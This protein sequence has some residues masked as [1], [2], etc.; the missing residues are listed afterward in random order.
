VH[1]GD[2]KFHQTQ[3]TCWVERRNRNNTVRSLV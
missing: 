2:V 3:I 1:R